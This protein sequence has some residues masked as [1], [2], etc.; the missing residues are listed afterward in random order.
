MDTHDEIH[1]E[2]CR[3]CGGR[4]DEDE[5]VYDEV[6]DT[7]GFGDAAYYHDATCHA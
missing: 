2:Q 3:T 5:G 6:D 7:D 4:I 1:N